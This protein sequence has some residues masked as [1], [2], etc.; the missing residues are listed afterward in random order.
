MTDP[1]LQVVPNPENP[2]A[3]DLDPFNPEN[4]RLDPS[5]MESVSVKKLLTTIPVRKP[6]KQVFFRTRPG[7]DWRES[8]PMIE[9]K[10]DREEYIVHRSLVQELSTELVYKT[11]RLAITR[12]GVLFFL[13]LR[14]PGPDGR[15]MEWWRSL[16]EHA[17]RAETHWIR[18]VANR[19]LGAYEAMVAADNLSEPEWPSEEYSFWDLIRIAFKNYLISDINHPVIQRLRGLA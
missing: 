10:D 11:L 16:R 15:D 13:P 5:T 2:S 12:Q 1:K 6:A 8:F 9:L 3:V 7:L 14:S 18:V 4:L 17:E 19:E